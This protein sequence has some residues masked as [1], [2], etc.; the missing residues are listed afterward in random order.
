MEVEII[1]NR[2]RYP[3]GKVLELPEKEA[4]ALIDKGIA[5]KHEEDKPKAKG[6]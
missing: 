4:L 1:V 5:K 6:K 2:K 3:I